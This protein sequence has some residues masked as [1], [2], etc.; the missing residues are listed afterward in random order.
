MC[1]IWIFS[2]KFIKHLGDSK[3]E[4]IDEML[5][6]ASDYTVRV[7]NLPSR[8][9]NEHDLIEYIKEMWNTR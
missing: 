2:V 5:D 9:Y 7:D 8:K 3:N 1:I 6:S 4:E